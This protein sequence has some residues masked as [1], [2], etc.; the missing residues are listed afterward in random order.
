M[1]AHHAGRQL[2]LVVAKDVARKDVDDSEDK[3][4]NAG[5][6]DD[7]PRVDA[8]GLLASGLLVE[9]TKDGN[10]NSKHEDA[11]GDEA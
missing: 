7:A 11:E 4:N 6:N 3:D 10:A 5:G 9:I 2:Q 8:E 1:S